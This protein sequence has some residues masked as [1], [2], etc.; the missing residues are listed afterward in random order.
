MIKHYDLPADTIA[1]IHEAVNFDRFRPTELT[2]TLRRKY[3]LPTAPYFICLSTIEPRK[4]LSATVDAFLKIRESHP[5]VQLV[6]CGKKGWKYNDILRKIDQ[7][8]KGLHYLGYVP[9][10]AL[11]ALFSGALALV[12]ASHY[13][14]FGLPMVEAMACG[15]PVIY[16][17]NS[18]MPEVV[19]AGG[20]PARAE[21]VE[22][23]A[24]Q[25]EALLTQA[26][27][28]AQLSKAAYRRAYQFSWLKVAFETLEFYER[29]LTHDNA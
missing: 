20:L 11:G 15:T 21:S 17:N 3:D 28:Q 14:G 29:T 2:D 24:E 1:T 26:D 7:K 27:L 10:E 13:E 25:M 18:S 5:G 6:V 22:S 19:R 23:I 8:K 4:N 9:D 12:Y 16:G